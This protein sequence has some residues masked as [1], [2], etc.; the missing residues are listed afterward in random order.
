[1]IA[2]QT[3]IE[4]RYVTLPEANSTFVGLKLFFVGAAELYHDSLESF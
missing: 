2:S 1:M 3:S 4:E